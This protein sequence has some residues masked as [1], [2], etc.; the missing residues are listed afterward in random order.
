MYIER[1]NFTAWMERCMDRF[2]KLENMIERLSN[3]RNCLDGEQLLDNQDL[4]MITKMSARTLQRYRKSGNL[5]YIKNC[6]KNYY[7]A[8]D[9]HTFI[10]DKLK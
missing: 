6:G 2:N 7:R 10:R 3:V 8:S 1:D 9:V 5:P 4:M